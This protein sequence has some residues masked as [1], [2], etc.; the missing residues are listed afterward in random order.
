[1][2]ES[3]PSATGADASNSTINQQCH[4]MESS[5]WRPYKKYVSNIC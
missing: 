2:T 1:M 5:P 3:R 4:A